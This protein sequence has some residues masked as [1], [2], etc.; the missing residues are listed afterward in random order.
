[1]IC[2][3]TAVE[4]VSLNKNGTILQERLYAADWKVGRQF[5]SS[6]INFHAIGYLFRLY[7]LF[8]NKWFNYC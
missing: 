4:H 5:V 6:I 1:M 3:L 2:T 7:R 8:V